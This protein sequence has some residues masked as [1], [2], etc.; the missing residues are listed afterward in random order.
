MTVAQHHDALIALLPPGPAWPRTPASEL[1]QF[2]GASADGLARTDDRAAALIDEAD[3]RS[4]LELLPD[5]ERVAGLPDACSGLPETIRER[6]VALHLKIAELGGQSIPYFV[7]MGERLGF[8]IEVTEF[9]PLEAGFGAGDAAMDDAWAHA[10]R[11]E[12]FLDA[13]DE[14]FTPAVFTA[15]SNAGDLLVGWGSLD[16]ECVIR[17]AAPAHGT[18]LFAYHVEPDPVFLHTFI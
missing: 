7:A 9:R 14:S 15:G 18:V 5:W 6:Q 11:V 12:V 17:R 10:W 3:P 8:A 13:A 4:A 16:L 2:L 1:G